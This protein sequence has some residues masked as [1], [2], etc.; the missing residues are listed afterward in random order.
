MG[1]LRHREGVEP[2]ASH[3]ALCSLLGPFR[4]SRQTRPV[5]P[6]AL[7]P[8][9]RACAPVRATIPGRGGCLSA[10]I[11]SLDGRFNPLILGAA[12][13]ST[14]LRCSASRWLQQGLGPAAL[15]SKHHLVPNPFTNVKTCVVLSP[16]FISPAGSEVQLGRSGSPRARLSEHPASQGWEQ[17]PA[18]VGCSLQKATWRA[19]SAPKHPC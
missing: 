7:S 17:T 3:P 6:P 18:P 10:P 9:P 11:R 14:C 15:C 8:S 5:S 16:G 19:V 12:A 13:P 1:K 4:L 2:R